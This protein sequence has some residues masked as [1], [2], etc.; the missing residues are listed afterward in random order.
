[1]LSWR[2]E[3]DRIYCF[4]FSRGAFTVRCVVGMVN[5]FGI[6]KPEHAGL[7]PTLIRVYF[8]L[9]NQKGSWMQETTRRLHR[10]AARDPKAAGEVGGHDETGNRATREKLAEQIRDLFTTR[11]GRA[12]HVHWVGVWD[13][14][15]SVGLPGPLARSNPST[16]TLKGKR[17][18]NVRHALALDEHRW[19][20]VPRLYE[21][22]GDLVAA[23]GGQTLQQRWF[24]GVH[25]DVGGSYPRDEA[26]LSDE[27]LEWMVAEVAS[28]MGVELLPAGAGLR[29]R[30]DALHDTPWWALA[31]MSLRNLQ[32]R[33]AAGA[34]IEVIVQPLSRPAAGSAW[35]ERRPL[36]PVFAA[37]LVGVSPLLLSGACLTSN[38]WREHL[39]PATWP[40][41]LA[42]GREFAADQLAALWWHGLVSTHPGARRE[43]AQPAWAM[44]RDYVFIACWAYLL[45]RIGSRAFTWLAQTGRPEAA[46]APPWRVLGMAPLAAV[47]G[48]VLENLST[49]AALAADGIGAGILATAFIWLGGVS[50]LCKFIGLLMC[51]PLILVRLWIAVP[52]VPK[53]RLRP[54]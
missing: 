39:D 26:G 28:D 34:P 35:S 50:A 42:A 4:G 18:R 25:C 7:L 12:A 31:G 44:F 41:V 23:D 54:K 30:H 33:T 1:M 10:A 38:G 17:V 40:Q 19:T 8:S 37:L 48:D 16:A 2:D 46:P 51:V 32:P 22:S 6:L 15:E 14:V 20:F 49:L 3:G 27:T 13:T 5:L 36:W 29:K 9:P 47:G 11:Q 53:V 24:A 45:A 52:G 43:G 21:E